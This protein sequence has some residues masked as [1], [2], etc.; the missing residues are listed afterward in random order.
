M[1]FVSYLLAVVLIVLC[2]LSAL[3]DFVRPPQIV[4][5][6]SRLKIPAKALPV[7]GRHQVGS[8]PWARNRIQ[9]HS[10]RSTCWDRPVCLFCGC[11]HNTHSREGSVQGHTSSVYSLGVSDAVHIGDVCAIRTAARRLFLAFELVPL[12]IVK[13][14]LLVTL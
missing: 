5:T 3:M 13:P 6:M 7:L 1:T 8:V 10:C 12:G 2:A 11:H 4:Q 14:K 9:L